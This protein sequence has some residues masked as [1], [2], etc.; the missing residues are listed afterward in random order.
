VEAAELVVDSVDSGVSRYL[1]SWHRIDAAYRRF[2]FH[3]RRYGQVGVIGCVAEWVEKT[4]VNNFLLPLADRWSDQVRGM[5]DWGCRKLRPQAAFFGEFVQPFVDKGQKLFVVVSDALRYEAA[6]ELVGRIRAENRWTAELEAVFGSLPSYTQ[7]GMA[8]LLPG[9]KRAIQTADGSVLL[10]GKN[11]AGTEARKQILSIALGGRATAIQA[12]TLLEMNTKAEARTLLRDND[13]IYVFH[14]TIDKV[15]DSAATE[16]KTAEA[17]ETALGELMQILKKIANANG[18]NMLITTDHGFLFQ[19][20]EVAEAD[21]LPLPAAD[22]W[23]M[24][25]R[26][27]ALGRGIAKNPSVKVFAAKNLGIAGDWHA[28]FPL[29]LGRFPLSGSGK[30]YV[31]GGLSLQEV[32]VPVIRVHKARSDDTER[33]EVDF[34]RLP[35]KI[36][37]GQLSLALYQE[38]PV[39]DKTLPRALTLGVYAADGKSLSEVRSLIFDSAEEEPRLRERTVGLTLSRSADQYNGQD[40]EIRLEETVPGTTQTATY[41]S[42]K[43]KLQKPFESDFDD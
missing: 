32:I 19:Q 25:N 22:E 18:S 24:K 13:V 39:N 42:Q 4:Y 14:N 1:A 30:R 36:T 43:V 17:V 9:A 7:L 10:D 21:D 41:K 6:G 29:S 3:Q 11:A 28:A 20:S 2:C 16:A 38:E 40:V 37:T 26:R 31:H 15:G 23:L 33:V 27:F 34:M 12:E 8:A 35:A 5:N